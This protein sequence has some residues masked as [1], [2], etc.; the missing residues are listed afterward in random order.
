MF[1]SFSKSRYMQR[2]SHPNCYDL[3]VQNLP[4][5]AKTFI[6]WKDTYLNIHIFLTVSEMFIWMQCRDSFIWIQSNS[7]FPSFKYNFVPF[8][9]WFIKTVASINIAVSRKC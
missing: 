8:F 4:W 1:N 2:W 3:Q 7:D 5:R 9:K 6:F